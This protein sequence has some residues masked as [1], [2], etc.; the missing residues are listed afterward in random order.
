MDVNLTGNIEVAA[1]PERSPVAT[2]KEAVSAWVAGRSP[3]APVLSCGRTDE[4]V[5][6]ALEVVTL[7][8][9]R[10]WYP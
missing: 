2:V 7:K 1:L 9:L 5:R 8:Q 4:F 6:R 10:L 3:A